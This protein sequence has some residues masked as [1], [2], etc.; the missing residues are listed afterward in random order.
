MCTL[1]TVQQVEVVKEAEFQQ[2]LL[3]LEEERADMKV[4]QEDIYRPPSQLLFVNRGTTMQKDEKRR[5]SVA[6]WQF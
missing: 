4:E 2:A 6:L 3:L 1:C 5:R